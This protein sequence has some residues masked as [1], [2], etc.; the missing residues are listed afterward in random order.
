M[1]QCDQ[2][3]VLHEGRVAERGTHSQLIQKGGMY[4]DMWQVRRLT[5]AVASCMCA[6]TQL[7]DLTRG[8][9]CAQMAGGQQGWV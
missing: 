1:Q 5:A 4:A 2:I 9:L 3:V 8:Q 6:S 7:A